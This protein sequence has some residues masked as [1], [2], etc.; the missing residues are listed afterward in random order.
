MQITARPRGGT[1]GELLVAARQVHLV[2][3]AHLDPVWLWEWEEGAAEAVSTFRTAADLCE[4]FDGFVFNH[5][6]VILYR[7]IEEYEPEL[8]ARIQRL[9]AE[10]RWHIC[11]GWY[12]QPD[13][14]MPSGESFVRQ[15]LVGRQYFRSHFNAEPT[16]A[17]NFD[18]FGHSWGLPQILR[19]S[20]YEGY[21]CCRPGP[22]DIALPQDTFVWVGADGSE[23]LATRSSVWYNSP[24]GGAGRKVEAWLAEHPD[25]PCGLILWGVGDHGGGPSRTDLRDL[26]ALVAGHPEHGIVHSTPE[27]FHAGQR[28]AHAEFPRWCRD[29]NPWGPGCYTSM[30]RIKQKHRRLECDLYALE[31]MAAS[32]WVQGLMDYPSDEISEVLRDLLTSEFHDILPGSSAPTVEEMALRLLDHGLEIASRLR[33]RAFFALCSGQPVPA[34]GEI[35]ILAYNPHPFPVEAILEVEFQLADQN[36]E[37]AFTNPRVYQNGVAVPCQCEKEQSNLTLDWR[38]RVAFRATLAPSQMN[39]FDAKLEV[40]PRKPALPDIVGDAYLFQTEELEVVVNARTGLVDRLRM[41]GVDYVGPGAFEPLV[42]RDNEDPWGM[43]VRGYRDVVGRFELMSPEEGTRFSGVTSGVLPSVRIIED[44]PVRTVVEAVMAYGHSAL[45]Q[46]Y[47]LPKQGTE[48]EV[49]T[50]VCW[51]EKDRMLK[52]SIPVPAGAYRYL[53]QTAFAVTELPT[54]G[55][56]AVAQQWTAVVSIDG[57]RALTCINEGTYGSDFSEDGLRMTLLHSP[58]YSGHPIFD[59]PIV[60][61]DRFSPRIDQGERLFRF[62]INGGPAEARLAAVDREA[63]VHQQCP[64]VL[65]FRPSGT[66]KLP[67]PFV[68]LSDDAVVL[69]AAKRAEGDEEALILRL[70]E[71]TGKGRQTRL[72]LPWLGGE[73]AVALS[74]FEV[75]TLRVNPDTGEVTETD[76]LEQAL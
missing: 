73:L 72:S 31:K 56:E 12:L 57:S 15:I 46:R 17:V 38:K 58:A 69:S 19:K 53:G 59:R 28:A 40:L 51:A 45:C 52:L 27:A 22:G 75:K 70:Y 60:P 18:S 62:W 63:Q 6:E 2:C 34:D 8:F 20:G 9:V 47:K 44:G 3:N 49:E 1:K 11:G 37:D 24:L 67:K 4:E 23:V 42:M 43:G 32:A 29:I 35:A 26:A 76:L 10:G 54:N 7:W 5:N 36:W 16:V 25:E 14:N 30:V 68:T 13:C 55:D 33:A 64:F 48:I 39:R 41:G 66:G 65:S 50:R 61:Q 74:P 21:L 71:P